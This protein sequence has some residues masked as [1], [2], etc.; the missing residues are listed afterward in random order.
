MIRR[1]GVAARHVVRQPL[2]PAGR[3]VRRREKLQHAPPP[4]R[5]P[6]GQARGRSL[7]LHPRVGERQGEAT[8]RK[9]R[10]RARRDMVHVEQPARA[11]KDKGL[12][13]HVELP[14]FQADVAGETE[15]AGV[16]FHRRRRVAASHAA[17]RKTRH[18]RAVRRPRRRLGECEGEARAGAVGELAPFPRAVA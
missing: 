13:A 7:A 16:E 12:H 9:I 6:D 14:D 4:F 8:E 1:V 2:V 17:V 18:E 11:P 3:D 15:M 10:R 5:R